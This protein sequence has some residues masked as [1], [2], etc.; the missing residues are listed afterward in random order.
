MKDLLCFSY[1]ITDIRYYKKRWEKTTIELNND[2][3]KEYK[4]EK[5]CDSEVYA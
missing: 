1:I 3:S 2:N 4:V 5:I